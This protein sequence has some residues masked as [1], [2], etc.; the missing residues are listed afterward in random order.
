MARDDWRVACVMLITLLV[1]LGKVHDG[2]K[3]FEDA[4]LWMLDMNNCL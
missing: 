2:W 1:G 4:K 3:L